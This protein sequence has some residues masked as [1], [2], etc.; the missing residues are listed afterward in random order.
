[1]QK[2]P[3]FLEFNNINMLRKKLDN[4]VLSTYISHFAYIE[5]INLSM[6]IILNMNKKNE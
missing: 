5:H 4:R 6:N 1:M 2:I 3:I